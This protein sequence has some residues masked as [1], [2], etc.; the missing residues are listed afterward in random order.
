MIA[1]TLLYTTQPIIAHYSTNLPNWPVSSSLIL[2]EIKDS[3]QT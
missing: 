1:D 2:E 3:L